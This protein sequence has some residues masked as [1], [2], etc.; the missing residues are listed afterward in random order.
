MAK[1]FM[2]LIIKGGHL[3]P[4]STVDLNL[5]EKKAQKNE[6]KKKISLIINHPID[7]LRENSISWV[8]KPIKV[9]SLVTSPPQKIRRRITRKRLKKK[10]LFLLIFQAKKT[11]LIRVLKAAI[12]IK[13]GQGLSST[14][15]KGCSSKFR[16]IM[17]EFFFFK[18]T[19]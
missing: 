12:D 15:W 4:N 10:N 3:S 1:G 8:W 17:K 7:H 16:V 2:G 11:R 18:M 6:T 9:P 19:T 14:M 5:R 13:I